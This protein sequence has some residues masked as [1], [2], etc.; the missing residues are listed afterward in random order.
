M[1]ILKFTY[2]CKKL[3]KKVRISIASFFKFSYY[4]SFAY[5]A[6]NALT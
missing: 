1:V 3:C 5:F 2:K 4:E 6:E